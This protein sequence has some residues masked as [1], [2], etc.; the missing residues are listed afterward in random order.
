MTRPRRVQLNRVDVEAKHGQSHPPSTWP[1]LFTASH[2]QCV[3]SSRARASLSI[4]QSA[5]P[6]YTCLI[7]LCSETKGV[8]EDGFIARLLTS[9]PIWPSD[10]RA[11]VSHEPTQCFSYEILESKQYKNRQ[12]LIYTSTEIR[13]VRQMSGRIRL[14]CT[15]RVYC[16]P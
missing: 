15:F 7:L 2:W 1:L 3:L 6:M 16:A 9:C 12:A 14:H 10:N 13:Q 8:K 4:C 11:G 5:C